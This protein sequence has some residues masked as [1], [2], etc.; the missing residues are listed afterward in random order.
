MVWLYANNYID[1]AERIIRNAARLNNIQMPDSILSR[2]DAST[3]LDETNAPGEATKPH[4]D[5]D[6]DAG[7]KD[8][9]N[10]ENV[11]VKFTNMARLRRGQKKQEH[12]GAR[13][14]LLDVFR[15]LRLALYCVCMSVLWSVPHSQNNY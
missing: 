15:N 12:V 13:Y 11:L 7:A 4:H 9:K 6:D 5:D 8:K 14:T 10:R 3:E 1:E 2:S